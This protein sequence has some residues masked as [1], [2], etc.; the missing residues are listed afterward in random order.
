ML[1]NLV[2]PRLKVV[3]RPTLLYE[4]MKVSKINRLRWMCGHT[5]RAMIKNKAIRD[6]VGVTLVVDKM[7][8]LRW[9]CG[10]T[11]RDKD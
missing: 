2:S 9:M 10:H 7:R 1:L 3:V 8:M 5:R 6:K 11:Q 4:Q